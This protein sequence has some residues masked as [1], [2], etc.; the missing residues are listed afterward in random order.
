[1]LFK[2]VLNFWF[3]GLN[4]G[5]TEEILSIL[6]LYE[7]DGVSTIIPSGTVTE[8]IKRLLNFDQSDFVLATKIQC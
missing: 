5:T 3:A 2:N 6:N 8:L 4:V 1:M 7:N